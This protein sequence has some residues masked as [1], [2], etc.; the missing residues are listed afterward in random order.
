MAS[1]LHHLNEQWQESN[2]NTV[3]GLSKIPLFQA[4]IITEVTRSMT[5][6]QHEVQLL[7]LWK[8]ARLGLI[9]ADLYATALE[10]SERLC[11]KQ[12]L[13]AAQTSSAIGR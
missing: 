11:K 6:D 5:H 7:G 4:V 3:F 13:C 9:M 2:F 8:L 12:R 10:E 1:T